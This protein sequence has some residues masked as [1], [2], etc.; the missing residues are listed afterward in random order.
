MASSQAEVIRIAGLLRGTESGWQA[1]SVRD[2]L[3]NCTEITDNRQYGVNSVVI[4]ASVGGVYLNFALWAVSLLPAWIVIRK[5]G[6]SL[7]DRKIEREAVAVPPP[8]GMAAET[9]A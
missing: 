1:I 5:I 9:K 8:L 6:V 3:L 4:M 2:L 7:G